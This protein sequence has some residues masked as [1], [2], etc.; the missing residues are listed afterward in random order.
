MYILWCVSTYHS[1]D[2]L[3]IQNNKISCWK[4]ENFIFE[5]SIFV[6]LFFSLFRTTLFFFSYPYTYIHFIYVIHLYYNMNAYLENQPPTNFIW[7]DMFIR[8][9]LKIH[10]VPPSTQEKLKFDMDMIN[11]RFL[12]VQFRLNIQISRLL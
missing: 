5:K 10:E 7:M 1:P 9:I 3:F 11:K 12:S 6:W 2:L 8:L 4:R